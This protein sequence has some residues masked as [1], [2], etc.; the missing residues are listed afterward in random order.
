MSPFSF[1]FG[2]NKKNDKR[3]ER[4][5]LF[6]RKEQ[7][8]NMNYE[9]DYPYDDYGSDEQDEPYSNEQDSPIYDPRDP[10]FVMRPYRAEDARLRRGGKNGAE[11]LFPNT[12]GNT[13]NQD[14]DPR[15]SLNYRQGHDQ[16]QH[17][18][19]GQP[20]EPSVGF[21][22]SNMGRDTL[23]RRNEASQS[24]NQSRYNQGYQRQVARDDVKGLGF[25]HDNSESEAAYND[26]E[27]EA[28][29]PSPF[30]FVIAIT[31][32]VFVCA[33]T[34]M[35]Y[36]WISSPTTDSPP[37]IQADMDPYKVRPE[38]PG[39]TA[40]PH[41]D[42]LIYERLAP[43]F[44]QNQPVERLLPAPE[45]PV[46]MSPTY[47]LYE[48]GTPQQQG[49]PT[50]DPQMAG[51]MQAP[52]GYQQV[53]VDAN[54]MP[55]H[56]PHDMNHG[57]P[58]TQQQGAPGYYPYPQ[59]GSQQME[60]Q[61]GRQQQ[62]IQPVYPQPYPQQGSYPAPM[63]NNQEAYAHDR[64]TPNGAPVALQQPP[65]IEQNRM[66]MAQNP[67]TLLPAETAPVP[68]QHAGMMPLPS[69]SA[70]T[71]P[72]QAKAVDATHDGIPHY[73]RLGTLSSKTLAEKEKARLQKQYAGE[74][75]GMDLSVKP[76][77]AADK[78]TK[79]SIF[80]GPALPSKKAA[81]DKCAKI[82]SACSPVRG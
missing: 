3:H 64:N 63:P 11:Q 69:P 13:Y 61:P 1:G 8:Q 44:D 23:E 48:P 43:S 10:R 30:K 49:A 32:L 66:Q 24:N 82:G 41:Q 33:V 56:H 75:S 31:G 21:R 15:Q 74:L 39:G 16:K 51:Q 57:Q 27:A 2:R 55:H 19:Y 73:L 4:N 54:G 7:P 9:Q 28:D 71:A 50:H 70:N 18:D 60:Q 53:P 35:A 59:Q 36:R 25:W 38:N 80:A 22:R 17:F 29:R 45:Q 62:S 37:L 81:A 72:A 67:A 79:Y 68:V 65:Y 14:S 46:I 26:A 76:F 40:F 6:F 20:E 5:D 12:H 42:K 58:P 78:K 34:W 52:Q 77:V 47:Q